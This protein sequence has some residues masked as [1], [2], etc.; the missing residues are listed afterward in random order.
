MRTS[1][2]NTSFFPATPKDD[3]SFYRST[4]ILGLAWGTN[5]LHSSPYHATLWIRD[6]NSVDNQPLLLGKLLFALYQFLAS[7]PIHLHSEE[8]DSEQ[9]AVRGHSWDIWPKLT[10]R[11]SHFKQPHRDWSGSAGLG[12]VRNRL[13]LLV[14]G[15]DWLLLHHL[16]SPSLPLSIFYTFFILTHF[17][18]SCTLSW[19]TQWRRVGRECGTLL[20]PGANPPQSPVKVLLLCSSSCFIF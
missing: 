11:V 2:D 3:Y 8:A 13:N 20:L 4:P 10:K 12:V 5:V 19:P 15:D 9:G 1:D 14:G 7:C 6:S 18:S 16:C 17:R